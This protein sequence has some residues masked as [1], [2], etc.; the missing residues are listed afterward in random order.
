MTSKTCVPRSDGQI[1][2][3][4]GAGL[5]SLQRISRCTPTS[6]ASTANLDRQCTSAIRPVHER[7]LARAVLDLLDL[8]EHDV[9][10][11]DLF[12][13]L[14]SAPVRTSEGTLVPVSRW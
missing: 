4:C 13:V 7:A 10:S 12:R 2:Q 5:C 11:G 1:V 8:A 9:P 6:V 3:Q 14:A